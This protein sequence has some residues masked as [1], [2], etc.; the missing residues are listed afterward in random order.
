M[1]G[2]IRFAIVGCGSIATAHAEA[3][4]ARADTEVAAAV[5]VDAGARSEASAA[6]DC[7]GFAD[8]EAMLA[9]TEV[10]AACVCVPP[11]RHADVAV[12]LLE[13]GVDVLCE[14]PLATDAP[15]ARSM[16]ETAQEHG[17]TLMVSS[18]FLYVDDLAEAARIVGVGDA[19]RPLQYEVTLCSRVAMASRW[20]VVPELSGGGVVMD[21]APHAIDI[22]SRV[23]D[24]PIAELDAVF[25]PPVVDAD[26][27]DTA[28][29][30]FRT[31]AGT[32]G[33]IALSWSYFTKD[34]DYLTVHGTEGT[35]RAGWTGG[36]VRRHG[37]RQWQSFGSGY[38]KA[39]AF[40]AQLDDFVGRMRGTEPPRPRGRA[41]RTL[42]LIE[43]IYTAERSGERYEVG[44]RKVMPI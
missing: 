17:R 2:R 34:L 9:E 35:V 7:P 13:N 38:D 29:V 32:P 12:E 6:W 26:V 11:A 20:N 1:S 24:E 41:V 44:E 8:V 28:Q 16:S 42:E 39:A 22:L 36:R 18:K 25:A 14:K 15:E 43:A 4:A 31:E 19:G 30:H 37:E 5:D 23:L 3:L 21:N 27:E 33:R 40:A 10:D